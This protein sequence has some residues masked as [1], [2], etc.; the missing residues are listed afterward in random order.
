MVKTLTHS[1]YSIHSPD[2]K[3]P[4]FEFAFGSPQQ[5]KSGSSI[6]TNAEEQQRLRSAVLI[7]VEESNE[8]PH[9]RHDREVQSVN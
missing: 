1:L 7:G 9:L 6:A 8:L 3:R 4:P 2:S 5:P